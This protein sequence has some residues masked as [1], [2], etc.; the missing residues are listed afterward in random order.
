MVHQ[1]QDHL[2]LISRGK[3]FCHNLGL[4]TLIKPVGGKGMHGKP[5]MFVQ[6][7]PYF[8]TNFSLGAFGANHHDLVAKVFLG[9]STMMLHI[10]GQR[11][12]DKMHHK[13]TDSGKQGK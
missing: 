13:N 12:E 2:F 11:P 7:R 5:A 4:H 1:P 8:I 3:D 9:K 6:K 10:S